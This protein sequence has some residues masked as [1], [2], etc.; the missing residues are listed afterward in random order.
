M[1][2]YLKPLYWLGSARKDLQAMPEAVQ[3][4]FGYALY[5]A[6]TGAKH[7]Q[8]KPLKGFGSAG[9]L[10]VVES[11]ENGTYRAVYTV[12]LRNAVYVLHCFQKKST[13]GMA[14]PRPDM[15]RICERIKT[16]EAHAKGEMA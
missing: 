1:E 15:D 10:E 16:A 6:Q 5:L 2:P 12:K 14:T 13:C 4:T 9:V 7:D 11:T 8:A 3:D